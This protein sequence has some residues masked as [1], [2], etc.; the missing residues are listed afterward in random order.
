MLPNFTLLSQMYFVNYSLKADQ[1]ESSHKPPGCFGEKGALLIPDVLDSGL[2]H[3]AAAPLD[4]DNVSLCWPGWSQTPDLPTL[5]SQSAEITGMSHSTRPLLL[6]RTPVRL[7]YGHPKDLILLQ[8]L[9]S[10]PYLQTQSHYE[11]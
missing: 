7:D 1:K 10:R 2:C 5:T 11:I 8:S 3:S 6:I 9:L 4:R